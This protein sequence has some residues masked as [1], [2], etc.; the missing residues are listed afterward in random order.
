M[1]LFF[2]F[3]VHQKNK[4]GRLY[5]AANCC[6]RQFCAQLINR[7]TFCEVR[8][9]IVLSKQNADTSEKTEIIKASVNWISQLIF[10]KDAELKK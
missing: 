9:D 3:N 10:Y 1:N 2:T 7:L 4:V 5:K 8:Q 6:K